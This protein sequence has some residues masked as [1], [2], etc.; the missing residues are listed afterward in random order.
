MS[1]ISRSRFVRQILSQCSIQH[2]FRFIKLFVLDGNTSLKNIIESLS[3]FWPKQIFSDNAARMHRRNI[4][5]CYV[6]V[7]TRLSIN[8]TTFTNFLSSVG[9]YARIISV[10]REHRTLVFVKHRILVIFIYTERQVFIRIKDRTFVAHKTIIELILRLSIIAENDLGCERVSRVVD[11]HSSNISQNLSSCE[12]SLTSIESCF[13]CNNVVVT[14]LGNLS[15]KLFRNRLIPRKTKLPMAQAQLNL[16]LLQRLLFT[17][18]IIN[19]CIRDI[20]G[21]T[22]EAVRFTVDDLIRQVKELLVC[23]PHESSIQN[24][25]IVSAAVKTDQT[26]SHQFLDFRGR[27]INHTNNGLT[28][29]FDLPVY[30]KKVGEDLN[31]IEYKFSIVIFHPGR[32]FS[33]LEP[34][35]IDKLDTVVCLM[36]AACCES[37]YSITHISHIVLKVTCVSFLEDFID[38]V[39]ARFSSRMVLLIQVSFDLGSKTFFALHPFKI[40]HLFFSFQWQTRA[41]SSDWQVITFSQLSS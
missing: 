41:D 30:K 2:L 36:R 34:H 8:I 12:V 20:I 35:L 27:G 33:R 5:Q 31:I 14:I 11:S 24:M 10:T 38:E 19:I 15:P 4:K 17:R 25:I 7:H 21:F 37:Q 13:S 16:E 18:E 3:I 9:R 22:K 39:D 6:A 32:L 40:Y 1:Q 26:E 28:L 23:V 29:T